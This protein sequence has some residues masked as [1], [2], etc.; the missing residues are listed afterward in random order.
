M[1]RTESPSTA[2]GPLPAR[3]FRRG[4]PGNLLATH[5]DHNVSETWGT[6]QKLLVFHE[7]I[8]EL[9]MPCGRGSRAQLMCFSR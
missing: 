5:G 1:A 4:S 6:L 8:M 3:S 9:G 7:T 2:S